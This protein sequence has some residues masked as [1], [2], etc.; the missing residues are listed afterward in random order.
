MMH[1]TCIE[2]CKWQEEL[3]SAPTKVEADK[4]RDKIDITRE[5]FQVYTF[6]IWT[7]MALREWCF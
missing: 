6:G 3:H 1:L 5:E 4:A 7:L 2:I